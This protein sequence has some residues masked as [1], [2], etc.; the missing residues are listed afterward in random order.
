MISKEVVEVM[1]MA[2]S[3]NIEY[4]ESWRDEYLETWGQ[5]IQKICDECRGLGADIP[6]YELIGKTLRINSV[7]LKVLL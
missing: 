1:F 7:R 4:K 2:E 5:G 6:S 3:Q